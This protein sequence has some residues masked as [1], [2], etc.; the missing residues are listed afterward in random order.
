MNAEDENEA[1]ATCRSIRTPA[2]GEDRSH[3]G[4]PV[5]V[6]R[7]HQIEKDCTCELLCC[8]VGGYEAEWLEMLRKLINMK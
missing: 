2:A 8:M 5:R 1:A 3:L 7:N 6:L 4:H